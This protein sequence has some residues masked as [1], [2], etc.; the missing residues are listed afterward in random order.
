VN[1]GVLMSIKYQVF[2]YTT[3]KSK[4]TFATVLKTHTPHYTHDVS[5]DT[6][7]PRWI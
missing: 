2:K 3:Q 6:F 1:T 7:F 4:R 5:K